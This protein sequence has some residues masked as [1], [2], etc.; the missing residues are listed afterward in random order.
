M[1][2]NVLMWQGPPLLSKCVHASSAHTRIT[3]LNHK[4]LYYP[5]T[6]IKATE[7]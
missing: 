7:S 4:E 1:H 5:A 3:E 2:F 6:T